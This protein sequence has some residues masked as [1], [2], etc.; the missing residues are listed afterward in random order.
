MRK[1][2][3]IPAI[4]ITII[5]AAAILLCLPNTRD[6][7]NSV[8]S[9]QAIPAPKDACQ[10]TK[11]TTFIR[12][13]RVKEKSDAYSIIQAKNG[14]YVITGHT[15]NPGELCGYSMFWIKADGNGNK[16]WSKLYNNCS[17]DGYAITQLTDGNYVAAG[18]IS[19]EFITDEEQLKLEAQGDGLVVKINS[20]GNPIWTRTISRESRDTPAKLIPTKDGGFVMSGMTGALV[21]QPDVADVMHIMF[22]GNFNANG[23][24]N[25]LKEIDA[26][27]QHEIKF[28]EQT[29]DEG[30]ILIGN[31]KLVDENNQNVPALVKL[32]KN[33][34]YEW[35]T[36][37]ESV[38]LEIPNL[39]I[40]PDGK[41]VKVGIPNKMHVPF[42]TFFT[43]EQTSDGGYIALGNFYSSS[44][45][46]DEITNL[47]KNAGKE[48][49]FVAVKVDDK[50]RFVWTRTLK[51]KKY[52]EDSVIEKTKDGGYIIMGNALAIDDQQLGQ[53]IK[54][55]DEMMN[56]YYKKY[57]IMSQETPASKKEMEKIA[58]TIENT[59]APFEAKNIILVKTDADFKYQWGKKIGIT[60]NLRGYSIIQAADSGYAIAGTWHTGIKRKS[61]GS[62]IETT[63]AMILKLDANGN[64]GNNNG[65]IADFTDTESADIGSY[66]VANN[67]NSPKLLQSYPMDNIVRKIKVG[68]KKGVNTVVSAAKTYNVQFC[69]ITAKNDT[70]GNVTVT[71]TR[72]QMKY[73]ETK[74]IEAT[75]KKGK[76][77]NDELM[78]VLKKVF[79]GEVKL[80]DDFS[81]GWVA[82]RFKRLVTKDDINKI[83]AALITI[84]YKIDS[85]ANGDFTATKIG[86]TL[87]FHFYLGDTNT[88]HLDVNY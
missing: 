51:L 40:G 31:I 58:D 39:T 85:N 49:N 8:I 48:L 76:T 36:G 68:D 84:G 7:L 26:D 28:A 12:S 3:Y 33:G 16:E 55:Y 22:L 15:I 71:K 81:G 42:G 82:Y 27:V 61:L 77:I 63:E 73:E 83:S 78:P 23:E 35:A 45:A 11:T 32:N 24:T 80:W 2:N 41:S 75:S 21:G 37:L 86:T 46:A 56:E 52:L 10:T 38:P 59:N 29:K 9:A 34:E 1:K 69:S 4:T 72:P 13:Y 44:L 57:P 65:L 54:T 19:G 20:K 43:A 60:K 14:E 18:E 64:L 17:S 70:A 25:W 50:G 74:E 67:L 30:Y 5:F 79:N 62:W 6:Y 53:R 88:G 66:I 47:T 87:N